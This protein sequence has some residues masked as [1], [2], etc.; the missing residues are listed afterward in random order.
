MIMP[1]FSFLVLTD[2]KTVGC[3]CSSNSR[4]ERWGCCGDVFFVNHPP[5]PSNAHFYTHI[6][7]AFVNMDYLSTS[8]S[9][10]SVTHL[11]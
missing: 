7:V 3:T 11:K 1:L 8:L 2:E 10:S 5:P 6:E 9:H 4:V